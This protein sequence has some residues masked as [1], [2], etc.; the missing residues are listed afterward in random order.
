LD[1]LKKLHHN[2]EDVDFLFARKEFVQIRK[3]LELEATGP[4]GIWQH[5]KQ[6][7]IRKRLLFALFIQ[8]LAQSTGVLVTSNYQVRYP[9][10]F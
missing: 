8:C 10:D 1:I 3:P 5:L 2:N 9:H 7:H 4:Q 6:A